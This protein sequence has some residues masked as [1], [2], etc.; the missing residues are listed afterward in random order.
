MCVYVFIWLA[1]CSAVFGIM[2]FLISISLKL[3]ETF[4]MAV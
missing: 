1:L 3:L 2:I 4:L